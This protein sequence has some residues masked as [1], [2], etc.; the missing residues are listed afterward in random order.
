MNGSYLH[1]S[2]P[3]P[4]ITVGCLSGLLVVSHTDALALYDISTLEPIDS[5]FS[6]DTGISVTAITADIAGC[7][8]GSVRH[9]SVNQSR[10]YV[11]VQSF[12]WSWP[13]SPITTIVL[14]HHFAAALSFDSLVTIHSR[15]DLSKVAQF[16]FSRIISI[17]ACE[18]DEFYAMDQS[19]QIFWI[20]CTKSG[21]FRR[22]SWNFE[23]L[24][25]LFQKRKFHLAYWSLG[26]LSAASTRGPSADQLTVAS[27]FPNPVYTA[28]S[29]F[30]IV[31]CAGSTPFA[32]YLLTS[33][34]IHRLYE[35][36]GPSPLD[37]IWCFANTLNLVWNRSL[38]VLCARDDLLRNLQKWFDAPHGCISGLAGYV[39]GIVNDVQMLADIHLLNYRVCDFFL[40]N[41]REIFGGLR[42]NV[43]RARLDGSR[44]ED[45]TEISRLIG[46]ANGGSESDERS[47]LNLIL[48]SSNSLAAPF[49][50]YAAFLMRHGYFDELIT[51]V[52][53]WG[54]AILSDE[55]AQAH[56]DGP[57]GGSAKYALRL[58]IYRL[59]DPLLAL[60]VQPQKPAADAVAKHLHFRNTMF[61]RYVLRFLEEN[62]DGGK[63]VSFD[64]P[65]MIDQM[66]AIRS[67][68]LVDALIKR[69]RWKEAVEA[70]VSAATEKGDL[71]I[72][73]RI[74]LLER[75]VKIGRGDEKIGRLLKCA[76]VLRNYLGGN[77]GNVCL[78]TRDLS[79][80]V[81][82]L[83]RDGE[84]E[85]GLQVLGVFG[86]KR[87]DL[88]AE[89]L[90]VATPDMV[91]EYL[92]SGG[93]YGQE[94]VAEAM[95]TDRGIESVDFLI[96]AGVDIRFVYGWMSKM[97]AKA[98]VENAVVFR[99][100]LDAWD[101]IDL[102]L[103]E[104]VARLYCDLVVMLDAEGRTELADEIRLLL[105]KC[106]LEQS[107]VDEAWDLL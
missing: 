98:V 5:R 23:K 35:S 61:Q 79:D 22:S 34:G 24:T 12:L 16:T 31:H 77:G 25:Q 88:L 50:D 94:E 65:E 47:A 2:V 6:L 63:A 102:D 28:T 80:I 21:F 75:A 72:D 45:D 44:Q 7:S 107:F 39:L 36:L 14:S 90:R 57:G 74:R 60:A 41:R 95:W 64:F 30:G 56:E 91:R 4:I 86:E 27:F 66:R 84:F 93:I 97:G 100:V 40:A 46:G 9:I 17:W 89:Y 96:E 82:A 13:S 70:L 69:R 1:T 92:R 52:C 103:R 8:D 104:G 51:C 106:F 58:K 48:S 19:T 78:F 42:A 26:F 71:G 67:R 105:P 76:V 59:L 29:D 3:A 49:P 32:V 53:R 83:A 54:S 33:S 87:D 68:H 55:R 10:A 81:D 99:R 38:A 15:K 62:C 85:L 73:E 18:N 43:V 20:R 11:S 101:S 37:E